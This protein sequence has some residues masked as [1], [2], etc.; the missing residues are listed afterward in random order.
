MAT[1][2]IGY[3]NLIEGATVT[4]TSAAT[5]YP[6]ESAYSWL[7][8]DGW[9]A[10]AA[11][12]VY[13]TV[14]LG[15]AQSVD[16]WAAF[17]HDLADNSGTIKLQ[18]SSDNFSADINDV[19]ALVT[20][21]DSGV[22]FRAFTAISARYWRFEITSTGAASFIGCLALGPRMDIPEGMAIG[23]VPPNMS[24]DDD[25]TNQRSNGGAFL[26][27]SVRRYGAET[28]MRFE[29]VTPAWVRSAWLPFLEHARVK[30]FFMSWDRENYPAEAAYCWT[31]RQIDAPAYTHTNYMGVSLRLKGLTR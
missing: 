25:V 14:D 11:G 12:T 18:Y 8:F 3:T 4:V 27:R 20:P 17:A 5:G 9:K 2:S 13:F 30:P 15:S 29:L 28:E 19:G 10:A 22:I 7:T 1:P 26:G 31:D 21:T 16:Y 24:F 23:F 6:K